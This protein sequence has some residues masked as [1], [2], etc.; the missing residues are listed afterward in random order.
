MHQLVM[1]EQE[2]ELT[3]KTHK[4]LSGKLLTATPS[5]TSRGNQTPLRHP[6]KPE[7]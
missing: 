1:K 6:S 5:S 4:T 3:H 7:L 2:S